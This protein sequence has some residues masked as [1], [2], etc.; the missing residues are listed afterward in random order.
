MAILYVDFNFRHFDGW[1]RNRII[2]W[3]GVESVLLGDWIR[4]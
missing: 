2:S 3:R 4:Y 1:N